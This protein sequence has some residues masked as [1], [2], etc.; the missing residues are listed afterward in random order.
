[1]AAQV[2]DKKLDHYDQAKS[3]SEGPKWSSLSPQT[4]LP[5]G[6]NDTPL[7]L[8]YWDK[9]FNVE[10]IIIDVRPATDLTFW[11]PIVAFISSNE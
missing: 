3:N 5:P 8:E 2:P 10:K 1:M 4:V 7:V 9:Q 11:L 6:S